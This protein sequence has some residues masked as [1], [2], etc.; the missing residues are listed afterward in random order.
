M[1]K[2]DFTKYRQRV[3]YYSLQSNRA[4]S[5]EVTSANNN[6]VTGNNGGLPFILEYKN[7]FKTSQEARDHGLKILNFMMNQLKTNT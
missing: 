4:E 5:A 1:E 7:I 6:N 3:F 2:S